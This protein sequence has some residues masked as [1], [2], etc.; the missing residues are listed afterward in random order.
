VNGFGLLLVYVQLIFAEQNNTM[1]GKQG[2]T[3]RNVMTG[4]I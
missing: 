1:N 4:G 3:A 2:D